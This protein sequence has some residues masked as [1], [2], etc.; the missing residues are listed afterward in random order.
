M[1]RILLAGVLAL[2]LSHPARAQTSNAPPTME[3]LQQM[4]DSKQF[5]PLLPKLIR[6][7]AIKGPAA[8]NFDRYKLLMLKGET[9]ANLKQY[10]PATESFTL[11][12][13][14]APGKDDAALAKATALLMKKCREAGYLPHKKGPILPVADPD[15]RKA[16]FAALLADELA[17]NTKKFELAQNS[18]SLKPA[19]DAILLAADM[20]CL[21][22]AATGATLQ[23]KPLLMGFSRQTSQ[24]LNQELAKL[25]AHVKGVSADANTIEDF[26]KGDV[27]K[28]GLDSSQKMKLAD[29]VTTAEQI[30]A[31]ATELEKMPIEDTKPYTEAKEHALR[32][33][34]D[35]GIVLRADYGE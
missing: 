22:K 10:V 32:V 14:E 15:Q 18:E 7:L 29:V 8:A 3:E 25:E 23:T 35:A 26:G 2:V 16:A 27:G 11:A 13:K 21:E 9:H 6:C 28:R 20:M 4:F 12:I 34:R 30:G 5:Q 33:V 24:M 31:A 17:A 1:R 19:L